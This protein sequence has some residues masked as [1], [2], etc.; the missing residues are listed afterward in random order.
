MTA[1]TELPV[2]RTR[3]GQAGLAALLATPGRALVAFDFDGTLAPIVPDPADARVLPAALA[4]LRALAPL[5]GTVAVVTG[6]PAKIAVEYG[7]LDQV[8]GV[9]VLGHYG[10]QRWQGGEL[11]SPPPPP[12]LAVARERLPAVLAAA[13]PADGLWTE[14]K[15]DALA[16]HTRR[17]ADPRAAAAARGRDR[18]AGRTGT[19]GHRAAA[20]RSGQ[21]HRADRAGR[22]AAVRCGAVLR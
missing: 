15:A 17:A 18:T 6:R 2:P 5:V 14:D 19:A 1:D 7:S 3:D 8:P 12:G 16:V 13:G 22:P 10:R 20:G 21:G 4:G 11:E 9:V